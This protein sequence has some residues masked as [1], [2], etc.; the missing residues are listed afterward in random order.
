[1]TNEN[2]PKITR[3]K[4]LRAGAITGGAL[5]IGGTGMA[6]AYTF[7]STNDDNRDNGHPH[8]NEVFDDGTC[9][10][11]LEF[12]NDTNSLSYFEYRI[13]GEVLTEG[14]DHPVVDGSYIYPGVSV[15]GRGESDPVIKT[16]TFQAAENMVEI[17]L[18][19]GGER[20]WDFDWTTFTVDCDPETK[21]DCKNGGWEYY[22][23]RNQGKCIQFVNTGKDSR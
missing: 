18:A 16:K 6:S 1:M 7:P 17:R 21:S 14:T 22:G 23:F 13:D 10:V 5:L 12:V 20:D 3:R 15:D 9:E 19:L 4:A 8:V 11:T 2:D